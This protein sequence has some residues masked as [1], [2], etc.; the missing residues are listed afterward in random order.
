MSV[1]PTMGGEYTK[2][3]TIKTF[4]YNFT[5]YFQVGLS[6]FSSLQPY[7]LIY[8]PTMTLPLNSSKAL[9]PMTVP[10]QLHSVDQTL[11]SYRRTEIGWLPGLSTETR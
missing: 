5:L 3:S 11:K 2:F 9:S 8:V 1:L 4:K 7:C 10:Y 6:P